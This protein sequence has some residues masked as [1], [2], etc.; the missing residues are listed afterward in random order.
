V[1]LQKSDSFRFPLLSEKKRRTSTRS[2]RVETPS[3]RGQ[4][5][6]LGDLKTSPPWSLLSDLDFLERKLEVV[7]RRKKEGITPHKRYP[8]YESNLKKRLALIRKEI[9]R[10]QEIS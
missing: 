10:R 4:P 5:F 2:D 6:I 8:T 7:R 9:E 3:Y 1:E